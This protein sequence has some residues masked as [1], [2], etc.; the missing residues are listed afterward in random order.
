MNK[1]LWNMYKESPKG[2]SCIELF[3]PEVEDT[4]LGAFNIWRYANNCAESK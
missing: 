4:A 2:K 3:N 1:Q